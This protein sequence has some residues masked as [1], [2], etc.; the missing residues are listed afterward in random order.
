MLW[1]FYWLP[2][3]WWLLRADSGARA[4]LPTDTHF[5]LGVSVQTLWVSV[6]AAAIAVLGAYPLVVFWWLSGPLGRVVTIWL[7]VPP[8]IMGFLARNYAWIALLSGDASPPPMTWLSQYLYTRPAVV[9]VMSCVFV[10]TAFFI[11]MQGIRSVTHGQIDTARTLGTPDWRIVSSVILPQTRRAAVLAF[12][13]IVAMGVGF[14]VTPHMIG[15]GKCDF[16]ANVI[17]Q[18]I[19]LGQFGHASRVA[20]VFLL[21]MAG[22]VIWITRYAIRRRIFLTGY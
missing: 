6:L 20:L 7:T 5:L 12:A 4:A 2:V 19:N 21:V 9:F 10:P 22:P 17:L 15:G 1:A 8:L 11:L 14:F 13:L 3:G 16:I 18:Y